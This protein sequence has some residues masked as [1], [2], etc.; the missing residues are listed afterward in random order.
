[1]S[2]TNDVMFHVS[3]IILINDDVLLHRHDQSLNAS[4]V[5]GKNCRDFGNFHKN[6]LRI[7]LTHVIFFHSVV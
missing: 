3:T 6:K 7:T 4:R 5:D 1:M 2:I